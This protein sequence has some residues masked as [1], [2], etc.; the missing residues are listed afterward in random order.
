MFPIICLICSSNFFGIF[1]NIFLLSLLSLMS[2]IS[3]ISN[4]TQK[5]II[6]SRNILKSCLGIRKQDRVT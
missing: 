1:L 4:H 6:S 5:P 3:L 2:L